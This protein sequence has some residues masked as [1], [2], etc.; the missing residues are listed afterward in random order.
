M[1][2]SK[3]LVRESDSEYEAVDIDS[4]ALLRSSNNL[5]EAQALQKVAEKRRVKLK[6]IFKLGDVF[7]AYVF[8]SSLSLLN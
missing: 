7:W 6:G 3:W 2:I 8:L 5:T 1:S 4:G